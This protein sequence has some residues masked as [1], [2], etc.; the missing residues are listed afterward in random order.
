MS[1]FL[2]DF[3]VILRPDSQMS[4]ACARDLPNPSEQTPPYWLGK[5]AEGLKACVS[6]QSSIRHSGF[7]MV[8]ILLA[9]SGVWLES[10]LS[11]MGFSL[12]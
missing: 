6:L 3:E 8:E 9:G 2:W 7:G 1:T 12:C 4:E 11:H 10:C 5:D